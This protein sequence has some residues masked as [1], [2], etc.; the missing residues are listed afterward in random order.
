MNINYTI[1]EVAPKV[2]RIV[3][4]DGGVEAVFEFDGAEKVVTITPA[5]ILAQTKE[6]SFADCSTYYCLVAK[7][8]QVRFANKYMVT[9]YTKDSGVTLCAAL[10]E[11]GLASIQLYIPFGGT[12]L[13]DATIR[14]TSCEA[15]TYNGSPLAADKIVGGSADELQAFRL[16]TLP[17][18]TAEVA[19]SKVNVQLT[20]GGQPLNRPN[21]RVYAI[22]KGSFAYVTSETDANGSVAFD[23][24][25]SATVKYGFKYFTNAASVTT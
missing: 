16:S 22:V 4:I 12:S 17:S 5:A 19:G 18:L 10:Q 6:E 24:V 25:P 21:V 3:D 7:D 13:A 11:E 1:E 2:S 8:G 23:L 14:V 15:P 9:Y 20:L